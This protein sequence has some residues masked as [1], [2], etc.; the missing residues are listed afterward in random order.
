[1]MMSNETSNVYWGI[2]DEFG[3][4]YPHHCKTKKSEAIKSYME[5]YKRIQ[6]MAGKLDF[7]VDKMTWEKQ[8][9]KGLRAVKVKLLECIFAK[10]EDDNDSD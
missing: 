9:K 5:A 2:V 3:K 1:M 4:I 7:A 6:W 10:C 8:K